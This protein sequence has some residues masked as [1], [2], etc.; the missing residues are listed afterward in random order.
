[1]TFPEDT[2]GAG[3]FVQAKSDPQRIYANVPTGYLNANLYKS[4]DGG[5][6]WTELAQGVALGRIAINPS[7]PDAVYLL[8]SSLYANGANPW[9]IRGLVGTTDGGQSWTQLSQPPLNPAFNAA[10]YAWYV[11]PLFFLS[12][13]PDTFVAHME[14]HTWMIQNGGTVWT[15][16]DQGMTGNLGEQVAIDPNNP[17]TLYLSAGNYA[18]ISKS[19][20][21]GKTWKAVFTSGTYAVA[22][23]PFNSSH[24]MVSPDGFDPLD[25]SQLQESKDGGLTWSANSLPTAQLSSITSI[26]FDPSKSGTI[27]VASG[28]G[29]NSF[30]GTG[31]VVKSTDGGVTW[32]T[33]IP[34]VTSSGS[35]AVLSLAIDPFN[36]QVV[37]A[38]TLSGLYKSA[39]GGATWTLKDRTQPAE[40]I[41]FDPNHKGY[42]YYSGG[43]R[44]FQGELIKSTDD[45]ETWSNVS[46]G[47]S[48]SAGSLAVDPKAADTLFLV[49]EQYPR[50]SEVGWSSDGGATW[51]WLSSGLGTNGLNVIIV[52]N[53]YTEFGRMVIA[54]SNPEVLY[55]PVIDYGLVSLVLQH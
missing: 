5:T 6:T 50:G 44:G 4:T 3:F 21:A 45:G 16:A 39:D 27:Y 46:L 47:Q 48:H 23:D 14:D 35:L 53:V 26:L 17:S 43:G 36:P 12:T 54:P 34:D 1:L 24:L 2:Y 29:N 40:L 22:V 37:L 11:G 32:S 8:A 38:G 33:L 19:T 9:N 13:S 7:N 42:V 28:S 41:S 51:V 15:Q 52:D 55:I 31:G 25:S 18:G 30:A 20:D 49:D 10:N